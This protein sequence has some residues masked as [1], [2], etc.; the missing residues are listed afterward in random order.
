M[1]QL[2]GTGGVMYPADDVAQVDQHLRRLAVRISR[3]MTDELPQLAAIYRADIDLLLD[4]R[5]ALARKRRKG[6]GC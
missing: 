1:T 5:Y 4:R 6:D 3:A 2:R